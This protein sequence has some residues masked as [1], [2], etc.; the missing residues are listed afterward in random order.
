MSSSLL[1]ICMSEGYAL[2]SMFSPVS[3]LEGQELCGF[4]QL[5]RFPVGAFRAIYVN[6]DIICR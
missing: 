5:Q 6:Y 4:H 1:A 3:L 2:W